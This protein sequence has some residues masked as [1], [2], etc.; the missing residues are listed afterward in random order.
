MLPPME[1]ARARLMLDFL[2]TGGGDWFTEH[3]EYERAKGERK[4][5]KKEGVGNAGGGGGGGGVGVVV[6]VDAAAP[7]LVGRAGGRAGGECAQ[8]I[9]V[10][11]RL[12]GV[13]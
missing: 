8:V 1:G 5:K 11:G 9:C 3:L 12:F 6:N 7:P 13:R 10:S 4:K 2:S